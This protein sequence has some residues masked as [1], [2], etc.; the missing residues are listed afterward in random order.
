MAN[1]FPNFT[2]IQS[3]TEFGCVGGEHF[4]GGR[5]ICALHRHQ[6]FFHLGFV[7]DEDL[8]LSCGVVCHCGKAGAVTPLVLDV[9]FV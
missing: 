1:L 5:K 7:R 4:W 9:A 6:I 2:G 8:F 3:W